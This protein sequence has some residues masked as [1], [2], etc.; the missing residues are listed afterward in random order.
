MTTSPLRSLALLA[1]CLVLPALSR[2]ATADDGACGGGCCPPARHCP[3]T[4]FCRP[5]APCIKYKCT[6]PKPV[7][8]VCSLNHAGYYPT[9]WQPWPFPPNYSHCLVPPTTTQVPPCCRPD[10]VAAAEDVLPAPKAVGGQAV[11]QP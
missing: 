3:V 7:C 9:C 4:T 2:S 6:C 10:G 11:G 5:K 8:D 1:A